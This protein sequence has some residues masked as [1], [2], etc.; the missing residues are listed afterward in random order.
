MQA[1]AYLH[2]NDEISELQRD[3]KFIEFINTESVD[4]VEQFLS[5]LSQ[6]HPT[7]VEEFHRE[8]EEASELLIRGGHFSVFFTD[9]DGT[10]KSYSCS[11]P[12]SIQP[13]YAGVIQVICDVL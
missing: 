1:A 5:S 2:I 6:F 12:S 10:L 4:N 13:A 9:R 7:S 8:C 3:L 11:Y